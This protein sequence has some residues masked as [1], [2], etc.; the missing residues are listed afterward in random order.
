MCCTRRAGKSF[1]AVPWFIELG[2]KATDYETTMF[3][4]GPTLEQAKDL[5]WRK[6]EEEKERLGLN[7]QMKSDPWRV[8]FPT[9]AVLKFRGAKDIGQLGPI[10]GFKTSM[11]WVDEVQDVPD[12]VLRHIQSAAGP[13]LR[14][15]GG[16]MIFSGTPG[17]IATG[18]W[19]EISTAQP[20]QEHWTNFTWS[21]FENPHLRA[22][23]KDLTCI[24][25]DEGLTP[26]MPRFKREYQG[27]WV[28]DTSLQVYHYELARNG[29]FHPPRP[30]PRQ[31]LPANHEWFFTMGVDFGFHPDPSA[32]SV[33]AYSH[34]HP[35]V[36]VVEEFKKARLS[37]TDLY[38]QGIAPFLYR[39]G[40]MRVVG[41]SSAPQSIAE[42]NQRWGIGMEKCQKGTQK[43]NKAQY[44]EL[45]NADLERGLI[46]LDPAGPTAKEMLELVWDPDALPDRKE[47]PRRANHSCD[48]FHYA[49]LECYQY[50]KQRHELAAPNW[51]NKNDRDGY[52]LE[53]AARSRITGKP[54]NWSD[55]AYFYRGDAGPGVGQAARRNRGGGWARPRH[56]WEPES[57]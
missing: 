43:K 19:W 36:F 5:L 37:I 57:D 3:Y 13:G 46:Q 53:Q 47:H 18:L 35:T 41:D 23:A 40:A 32:V 54:V 55:D 24:M 49:Y 38:E 4:I 15:L 45:M 51:E 9:G 44:I 22:D 39:Y 7:F 8:E 11:V 2:M 30:D 25:R 20:G 26:D 16:Q 28:E 29:R 17:P 1:L 56:A 31:A 12:N 48:A 42:I 27:L 6:F 14:D 21:L 50:V 33:L 10:R 34:T 52:I